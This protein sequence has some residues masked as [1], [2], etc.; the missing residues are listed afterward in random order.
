[1]SPLG[2]IADM[3]PIGV[4]THWMAELSV[5]GLGPVKQCVGT[6]SGVR[7]SPVVLL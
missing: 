1:M 4:P 7:Q 5:L 2:D 3:K 6:P